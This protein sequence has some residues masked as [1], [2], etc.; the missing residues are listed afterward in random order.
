VLIDGR[1]PD[2]AH[3]ADVDARGEGTVTEQRL[4][5]LIRQSGPIVD[6][7]FEIEFFGSGV[8]AYGLTLKL[9]SSVPSRPISVR[10]LK[11]VLKANAASFAGAPLLTVAS[12]PA[13]ALLRSTAG[14]LTESR[15]QASATAP[16]EPEQQCGQVR[17]RH[18]DDR[19][20]VG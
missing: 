5:Q 13:P 17:L 14:V 8:E 11:P 12:I 6:R 1:P 16:P 4:Y 18:A 3:G 10:A 9:K 19:D 20:A 15:F 2:A 7:R